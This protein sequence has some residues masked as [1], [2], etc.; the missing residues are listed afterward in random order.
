MPPG[1]DFPRLHSSSLVEA[2]VE[3]PFEVLRLNPRHKGL[4]SLSLSMMDRGREARKGERGT[5]QMM[6]TITHQRT[7]K[8]TRQ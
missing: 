6:T 7:K 3:A 1:K 5:I 2:L 4:S 8:N